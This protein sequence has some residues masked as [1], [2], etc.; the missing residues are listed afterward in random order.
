MKP[1]QFCFVK[2]QAGYD[3]YGMAKFSL[4]KKERCAVVKSILQT[5]KSSVRADSSGSRGN[6]REIT[7]DLVMLLEPKTTAKHD[8]IIELHDN[9]YIVKSMHQ[10]FDIRGKLDHYEVGCSYWSEK[11]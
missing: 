4:R 3:I 8:A 6:A 10:R 7:A 9:L 5:E 1:N 2:A 11:E